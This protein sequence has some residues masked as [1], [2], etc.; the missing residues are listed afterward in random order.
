VVDID[1]AMPDWTIRHAGEQDIERV[2]SLW[3]AASSAETVTDTWDGVL[4]P[5]DPV[6]MPCSSQGQTAVRSS[7]RCSPHGMGGEVASTGSPCIPTG[8][9]VVGVSVHQ[10]AFLRRLDR[11]AESRSR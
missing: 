3:D 7:G 11:L 10:F 8:G 1:H 9:G 2:L 5:L 4:G 6:P